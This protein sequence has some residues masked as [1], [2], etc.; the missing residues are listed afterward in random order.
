MSIRKRVW[1]TAKGTQREAFIVD[2]A[3]VKD[4]EAPPR[5]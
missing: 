5:N 2:Y 1:T 3:F 4:G